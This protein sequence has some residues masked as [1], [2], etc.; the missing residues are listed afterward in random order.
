MRTTTGTG[1][2]GDRIRLRNQFIFAAAATA[3]G[4]FTIAVRLSWTPLMRADDSIAGRLNA[5][6]HSHAGLV[7]ALL[8]IS[9]LGAANV[10]TA[11]VALGAIFLLARRRYRLA[12]Y[13]IVTSLGALVLD[14]TLKAVVGRLRPVVEHPVAHGGGN[15]FPS[16]HALD[17]LICYGAVVLAL[18]PAL[19]RRHRWILTGVAGS[20][21]V[22]IGVSRV[23]LGV[24]FI[25]DVLGGWSLGVAWLGV[26]VYA[27]EVRRHIAGRA[28]PV[29]FVEG[30]E[31]EARTELR[32]RPSSGWSAQ[33]FARAAAWLAV[34]WVAV[35]GIVVG[36]GKL[37]TLPGGDILG[38]E[39]VPHWFASHRGSTMTT[40]SDIGSRIGDTHAVLAVGLVAGTITY[41][42][43]RQWR[44]V[45]FLV[46]VMF[47]ELSLFLVSAK[48]VG[49]AR[50]DVSQL[51]GQLP[52][53]AY[54][55]GH[56]AATLCL[57]VAITVLVFTNTRARWRWA[58]LVP[59]VTVPIAVALSRVYRGM[60]HPTD[61]LGAAVLA[62]SWLTVCYLVLPPRSRWPGARTRTVA[63]ETRGAQ[64]QAVLSRDQ[65]AN[66]TGIRQRTGVAVVPLQSIRLPCTRF[67]AGRFAPP[68]RGSPVVW[69][70]RGEPRPRR[71]PMTAR[72]AWGPACRYNGDGRRRGQRPGTYAPIV[73]SGRQHG[74]NPPT[75][76]SSR[77]VTAGPTEAEG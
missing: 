60:H 73:P 46:A 34:G 33:E 32:S 45:V 39:T 37:V 26:T 52:T 54:P 21:I 75:P 38:D 41:G 65:I 70:V 22:G 67:A 50:P 19:G 11:V 12:A 42:L 58:F 40:I 59:P 27:F 16:G 76:A 7:R 56:V 25:S 24:H 17:S 14:P 1:S 9:A 15:S 68:G 36:L 61:I 64:T 62:A 2:T 31:P 30:V 77:V 4:L 23:M 74:S 6:V 47:G 18:L 53:S 51:D 44:P 3:F 13:V 57:Y 66:H 5:V 29:P 72:R 69:C 49:R 8:D 35:L 63:D 55:S 48:V 28:V 71:P 43:L 10:L 20:V